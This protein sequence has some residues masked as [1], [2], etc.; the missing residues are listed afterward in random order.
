MTVLVVIIRKCIVWKTINF[1][2]T[3]CVCV[4]L[5]IYM[6]CILKTTFTS[7]ECLPN[8]FT[9]PSVSYPAQLL[10]TF[11]VTTLTYST[12]DMPLEDFYDELDRLKAKVI[13]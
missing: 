9:M 10:S 4:L 3:K 13:K 11:F 7:S 2:L 5:K 8:K 12:L 6:Y 1:V